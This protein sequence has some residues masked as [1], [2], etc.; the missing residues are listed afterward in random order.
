MEDVNNNN[1]MKDKNTNPTLKTYFDHKFHQHTTI[2][3]LDISMKDSR[4][5]LIQSQIIKK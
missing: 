2:Q 1:K 3:E 4:F 5:M